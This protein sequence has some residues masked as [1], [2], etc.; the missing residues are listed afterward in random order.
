MRVLGLISGT[1]ADGIDAAIAEIH[2]QQADLQ[3]DLI[4]FETIAYDPALRDRILEVAAGFPLSVAE[5]TALDA[6]IAQS[7]ARA[8]QTL[9]ARSGSVDLIGSHGQTVY[10]QPPQVGQLG[11]SVQLAGVRRS[12]NKPAFPQSVI[13]AVPIWRLADRVPLGSCCGPLAIGQ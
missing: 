13:S 12:L 2:G 5:L 3:V 6:T 10:H 1:S 7:F 9:I 8:A 11:W 4:A